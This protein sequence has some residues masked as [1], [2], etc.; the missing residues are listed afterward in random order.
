MSSTFIRGFLGWLRW[1]A[2]P[3][4]GTPAQAF[5]GPDSGPSQGATRLVASRPR[6]LHIAMTDSR[7][8]PGA[9]HSSTV[10]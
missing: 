2:L 5:A 4:S 6:P 10:R 7:A 8:T 3:V 1:T 9:A